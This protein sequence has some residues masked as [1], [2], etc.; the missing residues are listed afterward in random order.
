[1]KAPTKMFA[2]MLDSLSNQPGEFVRTTSTNHRYEAHIHR[3]MM[4]TILI[5][6]FRGAEVFE[7]STARGP[8][9]TADDW[10][11]EEEMLNE[12]ERRVTD[13]KML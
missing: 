8:I 10:P 2:D 1:M 4:D 11:F 5:V 9:F 12:I 3:M 7:Y 13:G 6:M